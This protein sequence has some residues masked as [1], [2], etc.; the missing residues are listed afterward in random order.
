MTPARPNHPKPDRGALT[1]DI[2]APPPVPGRDTAACASSMA[3]SVR[4]TGR[5]STGGTHTILPDD[6]SLVFG[7][8]LIPVL[9]RH[10]SR[11]AE[12]LPGCPALHLR[13][14]GA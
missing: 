4:A 7:K 1:K 2:E 11:R 8:T 14:A 5:T 6:E 3:T 13:V 10:R 12:L 9:L